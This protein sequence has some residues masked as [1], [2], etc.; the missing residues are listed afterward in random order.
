M[1]D[2]TPHDNWSPPSWD[3]IKDN[4]FQLEDRAAEEEFPSVDLNCPADLEKRFDAVTEVLEE[5]SKTGKVKFKRQLEG[6]PGQDKP[7]GN[8]PKLTK[9]PHPQSDFR[10]IDPGTIEDGDVTS[11]EQEAFEITSETIEK[12][13]MRQD[14]DPELRRVLDEVEAPLKTLT[15]L[16]SAAPLSMQRLALVFEWIL[17]QVTTLLGEINLALEKGSNGGTAYTNA[18]NAYL[19]FLDDLD[20]R[21]PREPEP[22]K[23]GYGAAVKW[24]SVQ[25]AIKDGRIFGAVVRVKWNPHSSSNGVPIP[26][27]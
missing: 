13:R 23:R 27:K 12:L 20:N 24:A 10:H 11:A 15:D 7:V 3:E 14:R 19:K 4:D 5:G 2:M 9:L 8:P 25:P 17:C 21:E 18:T 16:V 6:G 1:N 26:H 22:G